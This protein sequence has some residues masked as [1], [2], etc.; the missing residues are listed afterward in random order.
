VDN[1]G[2]C[3]I[4]QNDN[5]GNDIFVVGEFNV[6]NDECDVDEGSESSS[7]SSSSE[8]E[9]KKFSKKGTKV[10]TTP[11]LS[12]SLQPDAF[13]G[14]MNPEE[15]SF[16]NNGMLRNPGGVNNQEESGKQSRLLIEGNGVNSSESEK[17]R[18]SQCR[19]VG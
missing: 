10:Y 19:A 11:G 14:A 7:N 6:S 4:K 9:S 13:R 18:R 5:D 17:E 8:D 12:I 15:V 3:K 16:R 2:C 1:L